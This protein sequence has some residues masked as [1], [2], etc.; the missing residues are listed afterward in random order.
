ME[1]FT[2]NEPF[3]PVRSGVTRLSDCLLTALAMAVLH[4]G[5]LYFTGSVITSFDDLPRVAIPVLESDLPCCPEC[6]EHDWE[7]VQP[8]V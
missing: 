6:G 8:D 2:A 4:I 7:L 1:R 5:Y 3:P